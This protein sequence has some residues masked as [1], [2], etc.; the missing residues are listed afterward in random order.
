MPF[1]Q[2]LFVST[3]LM[4]RHVSAIHHK[5]LNRYCQ[6]LLF[7]QTQFD[8]TSRLM[9]RHLLA[10]LQHPN[11]LKGRTHK[12]TVWN[13]TAAATLDAHGCCKQCPNAPQQPMLLGTAAGNGSTA[14]STIDHR[15]QCSWTALLVKCFAYCFGWYSHG[16]PNNLGNRGS[17]I[18]LVS[19][20]QLRKCSLSAHAGADA[21]LSELP[22][23]VIRV[24]MQRVSKCRLRHAHLSANPWQSVSRLSP[25]AVCARAFCQHMPAGGKKKGRQIQGS[26]GPTS[27]LPIAP[28]G[29]VGCMAA[30]GHC[31]CASKTV[32]AAV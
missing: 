25:D 12:H 5:Q 14:S 16:V 3:C 20:S 11:L 7:V 18:E 30:L 23:N 29:N 26:D 27:E 24:H 28:T 13:H 8:R 10:N 15:L 6:H 21:K 31:S 19:K 1:V 17:S 22:A 9:H 32:T 4:H 2:T